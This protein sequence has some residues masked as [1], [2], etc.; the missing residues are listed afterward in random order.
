[1]T[2]QVGQANNMLIFPGVGLAA[3]ASRAREITDQMF[4]VAAT[5]LASLVT[6]DRIAQ[7]ALYP[8]VTDL[9]RVS[10]A[11]ATAVAAQARR[12]GVAQLAPDD[13]TDKTV[14]AAMWHPS[15]PDILDGPA[16]SMPNDRDTP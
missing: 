7:G 12:N 6:A 16:E 11:V 8:P 5:T 1:V 13:D 4:A 9:R 2:H 10:R 15:Y 14:T 3:I